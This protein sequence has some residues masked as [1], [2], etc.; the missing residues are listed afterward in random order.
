LLPKL[1]RQ[2]VPEAKIGF[3]LH[4]PFPSTEVY[5]LLPVR[6]EILEGMLG[7]DAIGVELSDEHQLHPEM[8]TSALVIPH[9]AAKYFSV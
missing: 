6:R 8:S 9:P 7:A 1:L 3:F 2:R 4:I 5:R